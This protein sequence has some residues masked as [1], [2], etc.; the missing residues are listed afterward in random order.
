[1]KLP[2]AADLKSRDGDTGQDQRLL[3]A[4]V[5]IKR[6]IQFVNKR[7]SLEAALEL[8]VGTGSFST[9]GQAL[10]VWQEV[11]VDSTTP[12]TSVFGIRGDRG[13]KTPE[14][15][16]VLH[17]TSQPSTASLSTAISP[18]IVVT[19]RDIFGNT[20]TDFTGNVT[21]S[22]ATN[23]YGATLGG[24]LTVAAVAGVATFSN[25]TV[26]RSGSG[27]ALRAT[28]T[29]AKPA[30]SSTFDLPTSLVFT[31]YPSSVLPATTFTIVVTARDNAANTDTAYSGNVTI[32]K[33]SGP[34][35]LS[36]TL[37]QTATGGVATFTGI[38]LSDEG[39]VVLTASGTDVS[40]VYPPNPVTGG[41]IT[42]GGYILTA[43]LTSNSPAPQLFYGYSNV[44]PIGSISPSSY[45]SATINQLF[46]GVNRFGNDQTVLQLDG[47]GLGQSFFATITINGGTLNSS[48]AAFTD[49]GSTCTW[50][51]VGTALFTTSG[52]YSVV[53]T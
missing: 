21:L 29:G 19:A 18:A 43:A 40:L 34:G 32:E 42:V 37:T 9:L 27:Y 25:V 23:R 49:N 15:K 53:W 47:T 16:P 1:V 39:S 3:N 13:K 38:T 12:T 22:F 48:S 5:D 6:G 11:D 28:A 41:T 31:T 2:V 45:N 36:G 14:T 50:S 17:F 4:Y 44:G 10:Y 20:K 52:T 35:T 24:T 46:S 51:W 26:N 7:P 8:P 33:S 30:T